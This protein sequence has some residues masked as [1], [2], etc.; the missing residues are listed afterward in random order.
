MNDDNAVKSPVKYIHT[1]S[2]AELERED[3]LSR[4]YT[5]NGPAAVWRI[6]V[7]SISKKV[8]AGYLR[9]KGPIIEVNLA[10]LARSKGTAVRTVS[11]G[12]QRQKR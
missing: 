6:A 1:P 12:K 7:N 4:H 8:R 11:Q 3:G 10:A 5:V 9:R 2:H